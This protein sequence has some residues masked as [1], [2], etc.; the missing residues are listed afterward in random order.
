MQPSHTTRPS[1]LFLQHF[2]HETQPHTSHTLPGFF[3]LKSPERPNLRAVAINL[4]KR[5]V[6]PIGSMTSTERLEAS[7]RTSFAVGDVFS[8]IF[9]VNFILSLSVA[10]LF[11]ESSMPPNLS[12][13]VYFQTV[14]RMLK[15]EACRR[16][17]PIHCHPRNRPEQ[18]HLLLHPMQKLPH[19]IQNAVL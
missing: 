4:F 1:S 12:R 5:A 2:L 11:K 9:A 7:R 19:T 10:I 15:L 17:L 3:P 6:S 18:T 8:L 16:P 14:Q 13:P